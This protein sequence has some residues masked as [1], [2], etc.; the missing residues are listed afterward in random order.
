MR[1]NLDRE[2]E[3]QKPGGVFMQIWCFPRYIQ[4]YIHING[5]G[6]CG[7]MGVRSKLVL[8]VARAGLQGNNHIL[9]L[10][11]TSKP[12]THAFSS[13]CWGS[14]APAYL[15]DFTQGNLIPRLV[16]TLGV[17]IPVYVSSHRVPRYRTSTDVSCLGYVYASV[18][19]R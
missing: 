13:C 3:L 7:Q 17:H 10:Q 6:G 16:S 18:Y 15:G 1:L 4:T 9:K 8:L 11:H 19:R 12:D 2:R 5:I 14:L